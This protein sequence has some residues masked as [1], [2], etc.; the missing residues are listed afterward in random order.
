MI[1]STN[2]FPH[3]S[4]AQICGPS[5]WSWRRALITLVAVAHLVLVNQVTQLSLLLEV[6]HQHDCCR[7]F[8]IGNLPEKKNEFMVFALKVYILAIAIL[9]R[10]QSRSINLVNLKRE[11]QGPKGNLKGGGGERTRGILGLCSGPQLPS[12][13]PDKYQGPVRLGGP[14]KGQDQAFY[15]PWVLKL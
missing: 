13:K 8:L 4:K 11:V 12:K 15:R 7:A 5:S 2:R 6:A 3:R 10:Y 9:N 14:L 1:K